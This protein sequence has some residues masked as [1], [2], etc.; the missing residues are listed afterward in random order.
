MKRITKRIRQLDVIATLLDWLYILLGITGL[1]YLFSLL[2]APRLET[3]GGAGLTQVISRTYEFLG[4]TITSPQANLII[5]LIVFY[6]II[7]V[8][9]AIINTKRL[10]SKDIV[11]ID[12][13]TYR[14]QFLYMWLSVF[15]GNP[16]SAVLRYKVG[17]G[18]KWIYK[19][20][21]FKQTMINAYRN[22][23]ALFDKQTYIKL[24]EKRKARR[25]MSDS[26]QDL[27]HISRVEF[28]KT[29]VRLIVTYSFLTFIALFIFIPFYWMILTALKTYD[30]LSTSLNPRFFIGLSEMQWVNF[31]TAISRLDFGLYIW[32]TIYVGI[33]STIGTILTTVLAAFAFAR[34]EFKGRDFMFSVLLMTMMIPGELY[35]ITNFITVSRLGWLNSFTALIV[36]FMTSVFYIFFLRQTFKQIPDSLYRAA[37]VD[38]CGDFK[39]LTRV[40]I[41]IAK[42]TIITI[43]ILSAIGAWDAFIWPQ[44]VARDRRYWLIS[45]ALRLNTSFNIGTGD[46]ARPIYNLQMAATALVT[47]PLIIV[48]FML[49]KYIMAGVG[50]SGTKG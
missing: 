33:M 25:E 19:E 21:G 32:N 46:Q 14:T 5:S 20:Y 17:M 15:S 8:P 39:Y 37:Q 12:E 30:E 31:K 6:L 34:L 26:Q 16:I 40:M 22:F 42:P 48:F 49:K 28:L 2:E 3:E 10:R 41:P 38:G 9:N 4:F 27:E 18:I 11:E 7:F 44:L 45:V 47:V 13:W 29:I 23:I 35:V 43:T 36:P 1:I 50:R 24:A